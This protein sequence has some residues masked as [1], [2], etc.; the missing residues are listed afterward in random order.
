VPPFTL[1]EP[2]DGVARLTL[3]DP[4]HR[5]P[6][7]HDVVDALERAVLGGSHHVVILC[8]V[9]DEVLTAGGDLRLDRPELDRLSDRLFAFYRQ[10]VMSSTLLVVAASGHVR[11][12][13]AQ[14]FVAADLRV[15]GP[16]LQLCFSDLPR[17]LVGGMWSLPA[18]VGRGR[19]L[20]LL[21]TGRVV[22]TAEA[23]LIGLA[24]RVAD[25]PGAEALALAEVLAA[26]PVP[27]RERIKR[28]VALSCLDHKSAIYEQDTYRSP[29]P[30]V[31]RRD[32]DEGAPR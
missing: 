7:S 3:D 27:L 23:Q 31:A 19:A 11:G 6:I 4:A 12:A 32:P 14:L 15:V 29:A 16:H 21:L 13:G 24:D 25:D 28:G 10:A 2:C 26:V 30:L 17:G 9:S 1:D 8:S 18:A 20:D 22:G 5:N